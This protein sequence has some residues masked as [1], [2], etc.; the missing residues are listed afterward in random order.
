VDLQMRPRQ[1]LDTA[2]RVI[3]DERYVLNP[4]TS[5]LHAFNEVGARIWD[6]LNGERSL[7]D[8]AAAIADEYDIELESAEADVGE[9]VE[10]LVA[11]GIVA[12]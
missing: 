7:Q 1:N 3:D 9:F 6:L 8:V 10:T 5:E 12:L 2:S 4:E 11:K